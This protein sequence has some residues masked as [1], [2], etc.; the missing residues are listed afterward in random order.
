MV[1]NRNVFYAELAYAGQEIKLTSTS[2]SVQNERQRAV[3]PLS[4]VM[5]HNSIFGIGNSGEVKS[6]S[7]GLYAAEK[8]TAADGSF[9]PT[10]GLLETAYCDENGKPIS[11]AVF[12]LFAKNETEFSEKNALMT[13]ISGENGVFVFEKIP[14]GSWLICEIKTAS[15]KYVL[16]KTVYPVEIS[17]DGKVIECEVENRFVRGSVQ[18]TKTDADYP[19]KR[20]TEAVFEVYIDSNGNKSFDTGID[21]LVGK[22]NETELGVYRMDELKYG[23]YFL[24]EKTPP[25]NYIK[26]DGYYYFEIKNDGKTVNIENSEGMGFAN[27]PVVGSLKIVKTSDDG[28]VKDFSFRAIGENGYD[29]VFKTDA[30]GEIIINGLR[31]GKYTVSEITDE[32]SVEYILA[33]D[34]TVTIE[35]EKEIIVEMHNKKVPIPEEPKSPQTGDDFN[36]GI[37]ILFIFISAISLVVL[38]LTRKGNFNKQ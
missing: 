38:W 9:I 5:E 26:T 29:K 2:V 34:V 6:V 1:L 24:Y 30:N 31:L 3:V 36:I 18:V 12:G 17:E 20:L 10:D 4:K 14:F 33:E 8:L 35:A 28:K 22:L 15:E 13:A 19:E 23:G 21:K 27:K 32:V 16:N 7:F 37:Y 25:D 11:S